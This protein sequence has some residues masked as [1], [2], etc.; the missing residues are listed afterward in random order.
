MRHAPSTPWPQS[1]RAFRLVPLAPLVA[2]LAACGDD[3]G[4]SFSDVGNWQDVTSDTASP[5]DTN[6][7]GDT[8][9]DP[10][11]DTTP[12]PPPPEEEVDFDLRTPEAGQTFLYIP[13]AALD[14]LVIVDARSLD[15]HLVEVGL[16]PTVVRALPGD[17][18]AVVLNEGSSD[19]SIVRPLPAV[20]GVAPD[21]AFSVETVQVLAGANRLELAPDGSFAFAWYASPRGATFASGSLQDV[22]AVDLAVGREVAWNL[23]VGLRPSEILFADQD[24]LALIVCDNGVSGIRLEALDRDVFLPPVPTSPD[25]FETPQDREIVPSPDGRYAYVRSL[26]RQALGRVDLQTGELSLLPLPDYA[27][28][29]E[30]T[31]DG[32]T[33]VVPLKNTQRVAVI[34]VADAFTWTAPEPE[35][36][37]EPT[38]PDPAEPE[39]TEPEPT[40]PDPAEPDPAVPVEP[41]EPVPPPNP[42]VRVAPTGAGFGAAALTSDQAHALLYTTTPGVSAVGLLDLA[43]AATRIQPTPKE[44]EAVVPSPDG[45]MAAL[46]HRRASGVGELMNRDAYSLLDLASGYAKLVL[47]PQKVSTVTFTQDSSELF[48]LLPDPLGAAH[49]VQR[50]KTRSF[51]VTTYAVPDR[52]VFVGALPSLSKVAISLDNPT[53]WITFVDTRTDALLQLNSFEL[54]SFIR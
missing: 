48:A 42:F 44:L 8:W 21:P 19:V 25:A 27:S 29:L 54:N 32:L 10:G 41:S 39:P 4:A 47:V 11:P 9:V 5:T 2:L 40:E 38:E 24:R 23:A 20:G 51:A 53:G 37:P 15:V 52:P 1:S 14:A 22:S 36:E 3:A 50:V 16:V 31:A 43:T 18:G 49:Q 26:N 17:L 7:S 35:P 13:S 46:L 33:A 30:L 28:D 34:A 45:A 6:V 12:P